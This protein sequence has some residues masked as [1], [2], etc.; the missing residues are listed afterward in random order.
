M[1]R[2]LV[3]ELHH[4][5][6]AVL[7]VPFLK[8]AARQWEVYVYCTPSVASLLSMIA[9]FVKTIEARRSWLGRVWQTI[10]ELRKMRAVAAVCV[11]ADARVGWLAVWSGA[12]VRVGLPMNERNYYAVQCVSQR[13]RN[14]KIGRMMEK[15][16]AYLG[17]P[18][19]TRPVERM[20]T[21]QSHLCDWRQVAE[22]LGVE[23]DVS[24]PWFSPPSGEEPAEA[25]ALRARFPSRKIWALHP[26]ARLAAKRWEMVHFEEILRT[27]LADAP[28]LIL[29]PPGEPFPSPQTDTQKLVAAKTFKSLIGAIAAAD[30][31]LCLDSLAGHLGAALG[32]KVYAIFGSGNPDGFAPFGNA[33]NVIALSNTPCKPCS[34]SCRIP[35]IICLKDLTPKDVIE[36]LPES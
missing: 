14:L 13:R 36:R 35:E 20:Q 25:T 24:L 7:A 29:C 12:T 34:D 26:G 30:I 6:D 3:F 33:E 4:L 5:G 16:A 10:T 23:A 31:L 28:V 11:W 18:L 19:W 21:T 27:R 1:R 15:G 8:G 17:M 22:A 32:K 2:L 9:P